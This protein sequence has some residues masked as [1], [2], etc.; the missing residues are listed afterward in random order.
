MPI[1]KIEL[2]PGR[3]Q[4]LKA[5]IALRITQVLEEIS[6]IPPT[7]TTVMFQEVSPHDWFVAGHS[8]ANK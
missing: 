2:F 7:D 8:F 6:N 3:D 4:S 1:V 5:E